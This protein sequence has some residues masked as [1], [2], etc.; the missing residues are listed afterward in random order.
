MR[1]IECQD[2]DRGTEKLTKDVLEGIVNNC[3]DA[4][5]V[6]LVQEALERGDKIYHNT[7]LGK[8][9]VVEIDTGWITVEMED[10]GKRS[11]YMLSPGTLD[12]FI[13]QIEIGR[14]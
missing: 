1:N 14:R 10:T 8:H 11:I 5:K 6:A 9:Q 2:H 7:A 4:Q 3:L 13:R 12:G